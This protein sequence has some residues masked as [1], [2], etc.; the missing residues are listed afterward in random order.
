VTIQ[1]FSSGGLQ[2]ILYFHIFG[3]ME[4]TTVIT[5]LAAL[6][7]ESRLAIFRILVEAGPKGLAAGR[8][9]EKLALAPA[10]LSFHLKELHRA[11]LILSSQEGRFIYYRADYQVMNG[12]MGYL[13][14]NCCRAV[15]GPDACATEAACGSASSSASPSTPISGNAKRCS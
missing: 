9:G 14:E 10:T 3:N 7:Q 12:L 15:C 1:F 8:I 11:G 4:S 5:A 2:F 6:A 13:T